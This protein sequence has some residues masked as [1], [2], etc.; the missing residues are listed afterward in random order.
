MGNNSCSVLMSLLLISFGMLVIGTALVWRTHK[1]QGLREVARDAGSWNGDLP[2]ISVI[3]PARN[4]QDSIERCLECILNQTYPRYEVIVV[5]D[6]SDDQTPQILSRFEESHP[7]VEVLHG[8]KLP[9]G[10]VG[11]PFALHQ[12][13]RHAEGDWYCFLDA[14]TFGAPALLSSALHFAE[15]EKVDCLSLLTE[16]IMVGFWER[17]VLPVVFT[18]LKFGYPAQQVNDPDHPRAIANGQFILI[19]GPVYRE[20]GGHQAVCDRVDEDKALAKKVKSSGFRLYL[21]E[22]G[23]L[24]RTRMYTS[25][26]EM[27]NGWTKNIYLGMQGRL[28]LLAFGI[29]SALIAALGIPLWWG[30]ALVGVSRHGGIV[31]ILTLLETLLFTIYLLYH[32]VRLYREMNSNPWYSLSLPLGSAVFAAMM[33]VSAFRVLSGQGVVW[34]KRRY[35]DS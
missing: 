16:Q 22:G 5:E 27:W 17:V 6:R 10:W 13:V 14:D 23:K 2:L 25:L 19:K 12:G 26:E 33:I 4:E 9:P 34:K 24:V 31:S 35:Y 8:R 29:I 11:K 15:E 20:I 28:G 30:V 7:E 3:I 18:G 32:R 1:R 21:A